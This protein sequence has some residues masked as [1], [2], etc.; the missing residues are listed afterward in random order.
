MYQQFVVTLTTVIT[1]AR[2]AAVDLRSPT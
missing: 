1:R 2:S